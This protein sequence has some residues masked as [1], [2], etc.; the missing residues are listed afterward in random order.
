MILQLV[1]SQIAVSGINSNHNLGV[2][3]SQTTDFEFIGTEK[4]MIKLASNKLGTVYQQQTDNLESGVFATGTN[5]KGMLCVPIDTNTSAPT[6]VFYTLLDQMTIS[7]TESSTLIWMS[8]DVIFGCGSNENGQLRISNENDNKDHVKENIDTAVIRGEEKIKSIGST[9]HANYI[10]TTQRIIVM[11]Q[12]LYDNMCVTENGVKTLKLP[13]T[14]PIEEVRDVTFYPETIVITKKKESIIFV[15]G[16]DHCEWTSNHS[17]W[18]FA[19]F[20]KAEHFYF[21]QNVTIFSQNNSVVT[22]RYEQSAKHDSIDHGVVKAVAASGDAIIVTG[23]KG[24][25]VSGPNSNNILGKCKQTVEG[26]CDPQLLT[27]ILPAQANTVFVVENYATFLYFD[28]S[29]DYTT[30][31]FES[32]YT[33]EQV[34]NSVLSA[35]SILNPAQPLS[36]IPDSAK[37]KQI[38][39]TE[40]GFLA[41]SKQNTLWAFASNLDIFSG[42]EYQINTTKPVPVPYFQNFNVTMFDVSKDLGVVLTNDNKLFT[43]GQNELN[44]LGRSVY[45]GDRNNDFSG[46]IQIKTDFLEV[47]ESILQIGAVKRVIYVRTNLRTYFWGKCQGQCGKDAQGKVIV[48]IDGYGDYSKVRIMHMDYFPYHFYTYQEHILVISTEKKV[49]A[50]GNN[51][52]GQLCQKDTN[53]K[54]SLV[55]IAGIHHVKIGL[56]KIFIHANQKLLFC[57]KNSISDY[58]D[59]F[60]TDSKEKLINTPIEIAFKANIK[61]IDISVQQDLLMVLTTEGL[62]I[63]GYAGNPKWYGL[64]QSY[65]KEWI[66]VKDVNTSTMN[67]INSA[68]VLGDGQSYIINDSQYIPININDVEEEEQENEAGMPVWEIVVI[69]IASVVGAGIIAIAV[70]LILKKKKSS[71][72]FDN[73]AEVDPETYQ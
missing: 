43:F 6:P 48:D 16:I 2:S 55:N 73:I 50:Y 53:L 11:G 36:F 63:K 17:E 5:T 4:K 68:S 28:N 71:P 24:V 38:K 8:N 42:F 13:T 7:M 66:L 70:F 64:T 18:H 12:C 34:E 61:I 41:L 22:C 29:P 49:Y 51:S 20:S 25:F 47:N 67:M 19:E 44:N 33:L 26:I 31:H 9:A 30:N 52:Y 32:N 58:I 57:G 62:Y 40:R 21:G 56:D 60:V 72:E 1:L 14:L 37:F 39:A 35:G 10:V 65:I 23:S 15:L 69:T 59:Y 46:P 45:A 54:E 27:Q 3:T